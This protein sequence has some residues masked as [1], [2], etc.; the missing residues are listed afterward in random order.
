MT[1]NMYHMMSTLFQSH[2]DYDEWLNNP[3]PNGILPYQIKFIKENPTI[4]SKKLS[5]M[6]GVSISMVVAE[7]KNIPAPENIKKN[8][9]QKQKMWIDI[10]RDLHNGKSVSWVSLNYCVGYYKVAQLSEKLNK[11]TKL[12]TLVVDNENNLTES[13]KLNEKNR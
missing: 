5:D 9:T 1:T 11:S 2:A 13:G 10:I 3:T 6:F 4:S 8:N 7:R 12:L